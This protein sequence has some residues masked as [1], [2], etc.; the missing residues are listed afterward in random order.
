MRLAPITTFR[1]ALF[2]ATGLHFLPTVI[3]WQDNYGV[4]AFR[5]SDW[6]GSLGSALAQAPW[7][8]ILAALIMFASVGL[9]VLGI[10]TRA[11]AALLL[12][13]TFALASTNSLNVQ[14]LALPLAWSLLLLVALFG[15]DGEMGIPLHRPRSGKLPNGFCGEILIWQLLL[16]LFCAGLEK[17]A[18]GWWTSNPL[19]VLFNYPS[20]HLLRDWVGQ[21][22]IPSTVSNALSRSVVFAEL[23][24]PAASLVP[25]FRPMVFVCLEAFF[26][27]AWA[28]FEV[29]PLFPIIYMAGGALLLVRPRSD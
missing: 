13:S 9:G 11:S 8:C 1:V 5:V 26:L 27:G 16:G 20:G 6:N 15:R 23:A 7:L 19:E 21:A 4:G 14:T 2:L 28:V 29:P 10:A 18:A 12:L 25:F 22:N 24:I 17:L 3:A